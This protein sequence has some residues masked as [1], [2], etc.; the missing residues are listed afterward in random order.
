MHVRGREALII[1]AQQRLQRR[2]R[3]YRFA[4]ANTA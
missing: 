2:G 4:R 1:R 3:R